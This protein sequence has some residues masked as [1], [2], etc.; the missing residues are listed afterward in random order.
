MDCK[1]LKLKKIVLSVI[2]NTYRSTYVHAIRWTHRLSHIRLRMQ[3][4][5]EEIFGKVDQITEIRR[6]EASPNK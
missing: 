4:N 2:V 5:L 6:F 3:I 1:R